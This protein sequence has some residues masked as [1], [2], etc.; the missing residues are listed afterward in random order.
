MVSWKDQQKVFF[1]KQQMMFNNDSTVKMNDFKFAEKEPNIKYHNIVLC[2]F[3]LKSNELGKFALKKGLRV[4]PNC[5]LSLKLSTLSE[6]D[7]LDKF[8]RFVFNYRLNGFW[9]KICLEVLKK[10]RDSRFNEWNK[11][12]W[13]LGLSRGFW[14]KYRALR[15]DINE[16]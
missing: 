14:D 6:L 15:G 8:V 16:E 11:R 10:D 1:D 5:G 9:D 12:L 13:Q 7:D 4:C 2:P 3:C